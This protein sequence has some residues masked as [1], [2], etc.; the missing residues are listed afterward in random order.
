MR[1]LKIGKVQAIPVD[2]ELLTDA[3]TAP[4]LLVGAGYFVLFYKFI[5]N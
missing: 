3:A 5:V 1:T 4:A 2:S